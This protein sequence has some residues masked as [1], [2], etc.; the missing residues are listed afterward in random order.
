V[1]NFRLS[2][3]K[4]MLMDPKDQHVLI[5]GASRGIGEALTHSFHKAGAKLSL[6]ARNSQALKNVTENVEG[7]AYPTD[8]SDINQTEKLIQRVEEESGPIHIL[9]N[10]AAVASPKHFTDYSTEE[11]VSIFNVNV[12]SPIILVKALVPRMIHRGCGHIVNI[13]SIG[14]AV[15]AP[16]LLPYC[17]SKA[18]LG[19]GTSVLRMDLRNTPIKIT[20][21]EL[22]N[23]T[24]GGTLDEMR[25]EEAYPPSRR[26]ME[27]AGNFRLSVDTPRSRVADAVV[28]AVR[29]DRKHLRIPTRLAPLFMMAEFP[30]W[31]TESLFN[32]YY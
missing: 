21:V 10:N 22:S 29:G 1:Q 11:I 23:I 7:S 20:L 3:V 14:A 4:Q 24:G 27:I 18:G 32:R 12:L 28:D 5:T 30:R 17:S 2:I 26:Y 31:F 19:H 25:S 8:L 9:I 13:S 6:V 15:P 16:G